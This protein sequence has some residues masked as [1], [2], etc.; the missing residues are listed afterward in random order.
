MYPKYNI[1]Q[2]EKIMMNNITPKYDNN[3]LF[4]L[5]PLVKKPRTLHDSEIAT[6]T[7]LSELERTKPE[8]VNKAYSPE[9]M[10]DK[11]HMA[12]LCRFSNSYG[13]LTDGILKYVNMYVNKAKGI[14]NKVCIAEI[15]PKNSEGG[16]EKREAIIIKDKWRNFC[17]YSGAVG[18]NQKQ[19]LLRDIVTE[20]FPYL[21]IANIDQVKGTFVYEQHRF[22]NYRLQTVKS[23]RLKNLRNVKRDTM[24]DTIEITIFCKEVF[25]DPL[26]SYKTKSKTRGYHLYPEKLEKKL[27]ATVDKH[28]KELKQFCLSRKF[29]YVKGGQYTKAIRPLYNLLLREERGKKISSG[30]KKISSEGSGVSIIEITKPIRTYALSCCESAFFTHKKT[31]YVKFKR[32]MAL[33][34]IKYAFKVLDYLFQD[35]LISKFRVINVRVVDKNLIVQLER[36]TAKHILSQQ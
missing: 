11:I 33:E 8:L 14:E 15:K 18:H 4:M 23:M 31:G 10:R 6:G 5:M 25:L 17:K 1:N 32:T 34:H 21:G 36:S 28:E 13:F 9:E 26:L 22:L 20:Q 24:I 3:I 19:E 7:L 2:E 30:G 35:G 27:R 16:W 29:K 12:T